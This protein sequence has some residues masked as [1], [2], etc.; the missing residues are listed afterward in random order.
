V[1]SGSLVLFLSIAAG[2][3]VM[4]ADDRE[5]ADRIAKEK[6]LN[7]HFFAE[8]RGVHIAPGLMGIYGATANTGV[9]D[10]LMGKRWGMNVLENHRIAGLFDVNYKGMRVGV[11]GCVMC[12]FWLCR[13]RFWSRPLLA[14]KL[15]QALSSR[16][17]SIGS[18]GRR[19]HSA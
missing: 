1:R 17:V 6:F 9:Y 15:Q 12:H 18:A 19:N 7:L 5:M 3:S 4:A 14:R 8:G 16:S 2:I 10:R 13:P 11:A